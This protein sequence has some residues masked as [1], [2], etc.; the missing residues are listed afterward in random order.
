MVNCFIL[1]TP[2]QHQYI[3][4]VSDFWD[5]SAVPCLM[6]DYAY[7]EE[8]VL[9]LF[10]VYIHL[11]GELVQTYNPSIVDHENVQPCDEV[12]YYFCQNALFE[13]DLPF[14]NT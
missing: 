8:I 3:S 1:K 7:H 11:F 5:L 9:I 13:P 12:N 2:Q 10:V 4:D 14:F 6:E